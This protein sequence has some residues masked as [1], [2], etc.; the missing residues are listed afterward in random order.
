MASME[1]EEDVA[2][3]EGAERE[4]VDDMREFDETQSVNEEETTG[5]WW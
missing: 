1:D 5:E 4:N 3:M 2:A